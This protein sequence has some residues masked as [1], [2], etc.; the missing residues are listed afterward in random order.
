MSDPEILD[1]DLSGGTPGDSAAAEV[2]RLAARV[3]RGL[4]QGSYD[5]AARVDVDASSRAAPRLR[6]SAAGPGGELVVESGPLG[7]LLLTFG[8]ARFPFVLAP[9]A[10]RALEQLGERVRQI[11]A[12]EIVVL[13][14]QAT[15][16][17][18][19]STVLAVRGGRIEAVL[20]TSLEPGLAPGGPA[21]PGLRLSSFGG[22]WNRAPTREEARRISRLTGGLVGRLKRKVAEKI[23]ERAAGMVMAA[24]DRAS[25]GQRS[26]D[27]VDVTAA[28]RPDDGRRKLPD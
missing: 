9:D 25:E 15:T 21:G 26:A 27:A 8:G 6:I 23:L 18:K 19:R 22:S 1:P 2:E 24:V 28:V 3:Q 7:T 5:G 11:A 10:E 20:D 13:E 12:E 16:R 4:Q 17:L 14:E